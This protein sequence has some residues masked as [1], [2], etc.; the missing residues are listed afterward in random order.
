MC[1]SDL[2][3]EK[4]KDMTY[5]AAAA[6]GVA[7]VGVALGFFVRHKIAESRVKQLQSQLTVMQRS[8][9]PML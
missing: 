4:A 7:L 2:E 5:L 1:S 6:V 9:K 3:S 8:E